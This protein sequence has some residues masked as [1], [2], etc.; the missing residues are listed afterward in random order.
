LAGADLEGA[1]M[2]RWAAVLTALA[3]AVVT[4]ASPRF[5]FIGVFSAVVA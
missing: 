4:V 5:G 3:V 1:V 2:M